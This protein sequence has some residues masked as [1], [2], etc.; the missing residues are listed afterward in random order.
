MYR[1]LF[2]MRSRS[3]AWKSL[4]LGNGA[5]SWESPNPSEALADEGVVAG[6]SRCGVSPD[7][8]AVTAKTRS[9]NT[10]DT[11]EL[12][13]LQQKKLFVPFH[14]KRKEINF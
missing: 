9:Y 5:A 14:L 6:R 12:Q 7:F 2:A 1:S 13:L 11:A 10:A 4:G 3:E 8:T